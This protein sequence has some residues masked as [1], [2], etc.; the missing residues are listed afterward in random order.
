MAIGIKD[1]VA[2]IGMGC[3]KFGEFWDKS[4]EDLIVDAYKE[5]IEDA[6]I[7][8]KDIDAAWFG[9][10]FDEVNVGKGGIPLARALKLPNIPVTR[11]ENFCATGTE[12]LRGA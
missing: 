10:A 1:K 9:S 6:G 8:T 11:V 2:I 12:A 5:A 4:E 7:E 3:T